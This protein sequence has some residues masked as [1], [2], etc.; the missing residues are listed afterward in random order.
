KL[1]IREVE[2]GGHETACAASHQPRQ[3]ARQI[4]AAANNAILFGPGDSLSR[5][6]CRV[7][8][9]GGLRFSSVSKLI[10]RQLMVPLVRAELQA[11]N[12]L[13]TFAP[14]KTARCISTLDDIAGAGFHFVEDETDVLA[15]H[16]EKEK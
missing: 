2:V 15:D 4:G 11:S 7:V 13:A 10:A 16:A 5:D 8:L 1:A 9:S 14:R 3:V 12:S 6:H